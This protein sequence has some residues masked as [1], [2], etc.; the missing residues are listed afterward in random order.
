MSPNTF[1]KFRESLTNTKKDISLEDA[2]TKR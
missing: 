1:R 2:N